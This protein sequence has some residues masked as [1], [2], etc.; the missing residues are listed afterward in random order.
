[1]SIRLLLLSTAIA[2]VIGTHSATAKPIAKAPLD[3]DKPS[4][5]PVRFQHVQLGTIESYKT[6]AGA[7]ENGFLHRSDVKPTG[8]C[9]NHV[10]TAPGQVVAMW[11]LRYAETSDH[12][13]VDRPRRMECTFLDDK[14]TLRFDDGPRIDVV[15]PSQML[16]S[17]PTTSGYTCA[18]GDQGER[19][20]KYQELLKANAV[21]LRS[22]EI[23]VDD[24]MRTLD[25]RH[26][27][28]DGREVL[29][30]WT[31]SKH[32]VMFTTRYKIGPGPKR[33]N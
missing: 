6:D 33:A 32:D 30:N 19:R 20:I 21:E 8:S 16:L 12:A 3:D 29:C 1:M 10:D 22:F 9:N 11:F 25:A 27:K 18:Y 7:S 23:P 2:S 13:A 26:G 31:N 5:S 28:W 17:C 4:C 15:E 24:D 14:S